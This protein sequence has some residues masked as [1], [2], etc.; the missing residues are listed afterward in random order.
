[1]AAPH[2]LRYWAEHEHGGHF[3]ALEVPGL[4][5][6]DLRNVFRLLR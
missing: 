6:D 3:P 1:M 2:A 5:I 4:L